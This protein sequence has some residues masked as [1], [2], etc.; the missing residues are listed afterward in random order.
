M[1]NFKEKLLII[2]FGSQVTQLIARRLRELNVYCEIHPFQKVTEP[3]LVEFSPKAI[4]LSGG[5]A[6]VVDESSPRPPMAIFEMGIPILGI[7]YGQQVMMQSLGGKVERG[8]GTAEFGR[9]YVNSEQSMPL[10]KGWFDNG[11]EQVWMSHG[12]HVSEIAPGFEVFGTSANAPFAIVA[13][14]S[15]KFFAVQFHP[16]VHHTPKGAKLYQNFTKLA[17]FSGDLTM[18]AYQEKAIEAIRAQVG[19]KKVIC[20][21]SGGVDSSVTAILIHKAIGDQLTCVFVDN[22]LLRQGEAEEVVTMFRDNYNMPFIY[23]EEKELFLSELE[24]QSDPETKR[25]IIGRLF[26]DVFQRHASAVGGAQF[27]AQGTLYPD[28]IESAVSYTHLTLPTNREV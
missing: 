23:A 6:S 21:L 15:K 9:A 11:D 1:E 16:E 2:D 8:Q 24:G 17:G 3:F 19:D 7:C 5:P 26:I 13:N 22:G 4:I 10:L 20:G 27:L 25:K 12:D 28:V 18:G 14:L